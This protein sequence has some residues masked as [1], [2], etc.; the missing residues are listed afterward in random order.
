MRRPYKFRLTGSTEKANRLIERK[1]N[2]D[3]FQMTNQDPLINQKKI[4]EDLLKSYG[5]DN[6]EDYISPEINQ[7]IQAF[8]AAP[9]EV[10][11]AMQ[12]VMENLQAIE[13]E[14]RG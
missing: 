12:P 13:A 4:R 7:L 5:R 10:M 9:E 11:G 1:E 8:I 6:V 14:K 3:I 2:E